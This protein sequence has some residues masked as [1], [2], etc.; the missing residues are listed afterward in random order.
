MQ[1]VSQY[2]ISNYTI[3]LVPKNITGTKTDM[4]FNGIE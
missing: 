3:G 4:Q 1:E 2:L